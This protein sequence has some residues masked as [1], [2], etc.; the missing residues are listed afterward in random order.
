MTALSAAV[1]DVLRGLGAGPEYAHARMSAARSK[2]S[3]ALRPA[4]STSTES[5]TAGKR[6]AVLELPAPVE[7]AVAAAV[8]A[9]L[10]VAVVGAVV[11]VTREKGAALAALNTCSMIAPVSATVARTRAC[12]STAPAPA[13][14]GS[15]S[16]KRVDSYARRSSGVRDAT[17][18]AASEGGRR[19]A[20][21]ARRSATSSAVRSR[22]PVAEAW[23]AETRARVEAPTVDASK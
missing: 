23:R 20:A 18:A 3:A 4:T 1:S 5:A 15:R 16:R 11:V 10:A 21:N 14:S 12:N 22:A 9:E 2:R 8:A 19:P 7:L 13:A 17:W 6:S